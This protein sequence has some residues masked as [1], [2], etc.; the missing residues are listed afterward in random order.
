MAKKYASEK[1]ELDEGSRD[2]IKKRDEAKEKDPKVFY[3]KNINSI[4]NSLH[5]FLTDDAI[6]SIADKI[7]DIVE[8]GSDIMQDKINDNL[9][10]MLGGLGGELKEDDMKGLTD[11]QK[12][13]KMQEK[14][15]STNS[16][17]GAFL[18]NVLGTYFKSVSEMDKRSMIAYMLK[19]PKVVRTK[20]MTDEEYE[21]EQLG[22]YLGGMFKGAGPL[23][24]KILQGV[25][26]VNLPKEFQKA[27]A[28]VKSKLNSELAATDLEP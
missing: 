4:A 11:K 12:L 21:S 6:E 1:E 22:A 28:D 7:G 10:K 3:E 14:S 23:L 15:L 2:L 9:A 20:E 18:S 27:F 17:E 19:A 13:V 25:P 24:H 8:K 26:V 5:L 16:G